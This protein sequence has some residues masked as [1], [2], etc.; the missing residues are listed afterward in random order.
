MITTR[1]FF[2]LVHILCTFQYIS[3]KQTFYTFPRDFILAYLNSYEARHLQASETRLYRR[4][5]HHRLFLV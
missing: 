4:L 2:I 3:L 5:A 1:T